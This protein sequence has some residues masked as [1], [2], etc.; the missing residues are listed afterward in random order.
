MT[1][2]RWT[3]LEDAGENKY[4]HPLVKARCSCGKEKIVTKN[5]VTSGRS[6]SCGCLRRDQQQ[7]RA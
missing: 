2:T 5:T 6:K 3:I 4:K 7:G 1:E